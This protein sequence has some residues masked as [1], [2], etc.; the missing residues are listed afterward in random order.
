MKQSIPRKV[1]GIIEYTFIGPISE[2]SKSLQKK[3]FG[4]NK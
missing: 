2:D 4:K 3:I 1:K